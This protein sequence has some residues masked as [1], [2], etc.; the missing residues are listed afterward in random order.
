MHENLIL[1][2]IDIYD[3]ISPFSPSKLCFDCEDVSNTQ[4]SVHHIS[5]HLNVH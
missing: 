1:N 3:F 2:S 4:D 5:K